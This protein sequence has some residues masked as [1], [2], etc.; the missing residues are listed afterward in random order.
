MG[1]GFFE[2]FID[3]G[4]LLVMWKIGLGDEEGGAPAICLEDFLKLLICGE[5][6]DG[7]AIIAASIAIDDDGFGGVGFEVVDELEGEGFDDGGFGGIC[8]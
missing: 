2:D 6:G 4:V 1:L 5:G 3:D 7:G 8:F